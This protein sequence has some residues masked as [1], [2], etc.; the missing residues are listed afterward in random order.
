ML[1]GEHAVLAG[2]RAV[3]AAV[4]PRMSIRLLAR[5]DNTVTVT[6]AVENAQTS[7][8]DFTLPASLR[9]VD[10]AMQIHKHRFVTGCDLI[11]DSDLLSQSSN[12]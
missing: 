8:G 2:K 10:C 9:F 7:I 4:E 6:S 5:A 3:V 12:F 11:I 1:L